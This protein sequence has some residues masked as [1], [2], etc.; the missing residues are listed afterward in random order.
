[1][2]AHFTLAEVAAQAGVQTRTIRRYISDELI[3]SP[4]ERCTA[5]FLARVRLIRLLLAERMPGPAIKV[6]LAGMDDAA[7]EHAL[8][9]RSAALP[10]P[11]TQVSKAYIPK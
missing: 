5:G 2:A 3:P 9:S 6:T 1:M 10:P 11:R 7:V 8:A 4:D